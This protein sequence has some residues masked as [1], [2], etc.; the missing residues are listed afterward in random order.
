M[1]KEIGNQGI[2]EKKGEILSFMTKNSDLHESKP[3][4]ALLSL[5]GGSYLHTLMQ[6]LA[7]VKSN[8]K[9]AGVLAIKGATEIK[10][11]FFEKGGRYG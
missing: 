4:K 8:L 5:R 7:L 11:G 6:S 1:S 10:F 2:L 3:I 9:E